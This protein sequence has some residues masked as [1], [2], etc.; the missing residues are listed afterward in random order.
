MTVEVD[1][2]IKIEQSGA[3]VLAFANGVSHAIVIPGRTKVAAYKL[4]LLKG[5]TPAVAYLLVFAACLYLLLKDHLDQL[6]RVVIDQE[7][8]GQETNLKSFLLEY[9]KRE[10]YGFEADQITFAL[11]GKHSP[12]HRKAEQVRVRKD[13]Q[14]RRIRQAELLRVIA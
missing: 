2:S 13:P 7:Y 10:G 4:L 8:V 14:Y 12:A 3:T 5:K 9:L 1:Q 11:V 6:H